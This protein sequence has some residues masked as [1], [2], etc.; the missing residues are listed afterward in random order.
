MIRGVP[1]GSGKTSRQ[2]EENAEGK[3][4]IFRGLE[5]SIGTEKLRRRINLRRLVE[6]DPEIYRG[7]MTSRARTPSGS[8]TI[9]SR[10]PPPI[11]GTW[12]F[13]PFLLLHLFFS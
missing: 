7:T 9:S 1:S 6:T 2:T 8:L 11:E 5:S 12:S 13:T 4:K 10:G 3:G